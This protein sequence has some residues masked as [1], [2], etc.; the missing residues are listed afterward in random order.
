MFRGRDIM[1]QMMCQKG[2]MDGFKP[3]Y[4]PGLKESMGHSYIKY[5]GNI[6][7]TT[8]IKDGL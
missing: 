1:S 8:T 6:S 4:V 7:T 2:S 3:R 5:L